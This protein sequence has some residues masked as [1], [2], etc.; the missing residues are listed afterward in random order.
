MQILSTRVK[1]E[2]Q[3]VLVRILARLLW[4]VLTLKPEKTLNKELQ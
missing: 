2:Y 1:C 4:T 3:V